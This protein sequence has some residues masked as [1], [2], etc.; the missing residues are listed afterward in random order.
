MK[1]SRK[2]WTCLNC[3]DQVDERYEVCWKCQ[4]YRSGQVAPGFSTVEIEDPA[5]AEALSTKWSDKNCV[6]CK[7]ELTYVGRKEFH[8][9]MRWGALGDLAELFV[10]NTALEMYFCPTCRRVE[11]FM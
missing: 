1:D 7:C 3:N 4:H 5:Q 11:F 2:Y 10:S 8:E 6:A 9:G